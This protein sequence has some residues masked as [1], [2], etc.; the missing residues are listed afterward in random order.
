M[1]GLDRPKTGAELLVRRLRDHGVRHI[2]GYP[3][4]QIAPI[5]D[6]LYQE[7]SIRHILARD[8]QAAAFMADGYARATGRPGLCLA[9]CGPGVYNAATPLATSFADSIPVLLLS[10]QVPSKARGLRSGYYHENEQLLAC[11]ALTKRAARADDVASIVPELDRS[12]TTIAERRPGPGLLEIPLDVLRADCAGVALDSTIMVPVPLSPKKA[13]LEGLARLLQS[14]QRPLILAGGG[15]ISAGASGLLTQLAER[16]GAPVFHTLVGKGA[17]PA[18]HPLAE[19]LPWRR[20]T[21]DLT[22]MELYHSPLFA[23]ADGLLAVGCRFTQAATG[24]W[25]LKPPPSV[26]QIDI[27]ATEIGRHCPVAAGVQSDARQALESLLKLLPEG[28]RKRWARGKTT[29]EPWRLP[30][31]DLIGPLRAALPRHA[32]VVADITRLA[33]MMLAEFPV[34]EP[35]TFLHP[36]GFVSMGYGLPAALG[37]KV[38]FP[39]RT[40]V[41]VM[42]DGCFLMCGMELATAVQ[43]KLPVIAIVINDSSLTLIKAI[44]SRKYE[45]RY[46]GV[47]L[48]N[49]DFGLFAKAFGVRAWQVNSDGAFATAIKEAIAS[50]QPAL[51][52]VQVAGL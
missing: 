29:E 39:D 11:T 40:V 42:G 20:A 22:N 14:W 25:T 45:G 30:G 27:D 12:L 43:E 17:I 24:N 23:E 34:F 46:I 15:V 50:N 3:G 6:A 8:E 33:Y 26:A 38:A 19:R 51:I 28:K 18:D 48:R 21:S 41:T 1:A 16:L 9:V 32:I 10:G 7:P 44:Q 31:I 49:P 4:G 13:D 47:D 36:A 37:A 35:R 2:F 52:E 5:Y